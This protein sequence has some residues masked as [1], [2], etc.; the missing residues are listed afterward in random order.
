MVEDPATLESEIRSETGL[1]GQLNG[2]GHSWEVG[3]DSADFL[4][5]L[6]LGRAFANGS[7][8]YTRGDAAAQRPYPRCSARRPS[9]AMVLRMTGPSTTRD[10]RVLP[11]PQDVG[12]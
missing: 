3:L 8:R 11:N 10:T 2:C 4:H 9:S 7:A 5:E 6:S 1:N 12:R